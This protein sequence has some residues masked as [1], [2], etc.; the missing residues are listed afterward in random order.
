MGISWTTS[1]SPPPSR[2]KLPNP[3]RNSTVVTTGWTNILSFLKGILSVLFF[4]CSSIQHLTK[5]KVAIT[6]FRWC[7]GSYQSFLN[8]SDHRF[9]HS[10][11][12][13]LILCQV[14]CFQKNSVNIPR[15]QPP[16]NLNNFLSI[17]KTFEGLNLLFFLQNLGHWAL[18]LT[19]SIWKRPHRLWLKNPKRG[20]N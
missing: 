5:L 4:C 13:Q 1:L 11:W 2:P 15:I 14:Y 20:I 12:D 8:F 19:P 10:Q 9:Q 17:F 6:A 7:A 18:E 16:L 3:P